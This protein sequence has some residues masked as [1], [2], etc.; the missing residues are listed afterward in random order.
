MS[1]TKADIVHSIYI[2]CGCTKKESIE[3][4]ES[5]LDLMKKT[6]E[7]GEDVLI[8]G[9]GKFCVK[10]KSERRGRNPTTGEDLGLG[11][12]RVVTFRSSSVLKQKINA[13]E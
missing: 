1:L 13:K 6:L 2:H 5:V 4:M 11:A 3:L 7:S 8:S 12:R 10:D 9:F